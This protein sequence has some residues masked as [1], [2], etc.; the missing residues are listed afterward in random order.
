MKIKIIKNFYL[1]NNCYPNNLYKHLHFTQIKLWIQIKDVINKL[2]LKRQDY[3][4][5]KMI[6]LKIFL[7]C[8]MSNNKFILLDNK[9]F[10]KIKIFLK[11]RETQNH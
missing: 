8:K 1:Q 7:N 11:I 6:K 10:R 5:I 3:M 2:D 9:I 4:M